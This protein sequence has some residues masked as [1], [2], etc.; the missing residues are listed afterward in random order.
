MK[1]V[2]WGTFTYEDWSMYIAT[3][4][5]GLCYIGTP[6]KS[7]DELITAIER[8]FPKAILRKNQAKAEKYNDK[9]TTYLN[10]N[11]KSLHIPIDLVGTEFQLAVW[12]ALLDVPYGM[13][14]TYTDIA[15]AIERPTAVRAVGAAI[16]A[17]PVLMVVPCHRVIGKSGSLVGFRAGMDMKIRLLELEGSLPK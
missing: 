3:T 15:K 9:L 14:H 13:V 10:N 7:V 17:N 12:Q 4:E 2:Y 8:K 11:V 1:Y 5:I 16:G 6:N